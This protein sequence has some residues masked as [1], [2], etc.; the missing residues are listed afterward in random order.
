MDPSNPSCPV[1]LAGY[2]N[3]NPFGSKK[4]EFKDYYLFVPEECFKISN[5]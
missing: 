4:M 2:Y 3:T 5:L 1:G